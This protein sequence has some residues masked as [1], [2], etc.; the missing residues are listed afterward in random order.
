VDS[1]RGRTT[2]PGPRS[3]GVPPEVARPLPVHLL[4]T[5]CWM[6]QRRGARP[7]A[8]AQSGGAGRA[9]PA[10]EALLPRRL[11]D[12]GRAAGRRSVKYMASSGGSSQGGRRRLSRDELVGLDG[13]LLEDATPPTRSSRSEPR[14]KGRR[15]RLGGQL[16]KPGLGGARSHELADGPCLRRSVPVFGSQSAFERTQHLATGSLS[17]ERIGVGREEPLRT[18]HEP[19]QADLVTAPEAKS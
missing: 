4:T 12:A 15:C 1:S 10:R 8:G 3:C 5:A 7:R 2:S 14:Q 18:P 6:Q 13:A 9:R 19:I 16:D 11:Q 17:P